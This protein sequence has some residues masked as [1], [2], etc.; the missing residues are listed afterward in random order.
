ML[1]VSMRVYLVTDRKLV[2]HGGGLVEAV[3]KALK[4][5]VR[6][7]QLR[8]KD[9]TGRELLELACEL[10]RLTER[11]EARLLVNDRLDVA[12]LS[13]ADGVHL[14]RGSFSPS[15]A[16]AHLHEDAL[17]GV[18]THSVDEAVEARAQGADFVTLGPIYHTPSKAAYGE[19]LGTAVLAQARRLVGIPVFAIGG[20]KP[21]NAADVIAA[22]A[23]GVAVISAVL[24]GD[25][26]ERS[27]A[28]LV[29]A[30]KGQ[31]G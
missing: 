15:Q 20:V 27:A 23:D 19:P 28:A 5:G 12:L 25:D 7:V 9:L 13:R 30:V 6:L 21:E 3:E 24:A 29:E 8:E 1:D 4:G 10:R 16:R 17:I 22:G 14:G 26:M 2:R 11:Y 18:S 31:G